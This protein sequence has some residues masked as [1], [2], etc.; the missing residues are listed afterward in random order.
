MIWKSGGRFSG[1]I[2]RQQKNWSVMA[3]QPIALKRA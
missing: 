1:E 2:M 3:L